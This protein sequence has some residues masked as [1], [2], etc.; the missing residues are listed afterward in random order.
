MGEMIPVDISQLGQVRKF[1]EKAQVDWINCGYFVFNR[2]IFNYLGDINCVL[3]QEP[4][5]TIAAKGELMAYRHDG[6]WI[7]MDTYREYELLNRLWDTGKAP[8]KS[9]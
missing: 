4:M 7:G 2:E 9:W 5:Q 1:R 8:W 3:E 6:F